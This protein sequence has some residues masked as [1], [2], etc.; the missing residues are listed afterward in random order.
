MKTTKPDTDRRG[1]SALVITTALTLVFLTG[2]GKKNTFVPPPPP[3]VTVAHPVVRD[4]TA[5]HQFTGKTASVA[6]VEIRARVQGWIEKRLFDDGQ[7]VHKGDVL[8]IIDKRPYEAAVQQ[9]K[10]DLLNAKT[11][12]AFA[13]NDLARREKAYKEHAISELDL[14]RSRAERDKAAA[15]VAAAEA[16]LE[17][18]KINLDY[19]TIRSPITGK[20]SRRLVD[21]G[22]LVGA[23]EPTL[24]TTVVQVN[25]IY[26]YFNVSERDVARY[27]KA[28]SEYH[29]AGRR[30]TEQ[31]VIVELGVATEEGYPHRGLL[32]YVDNQVDPET[33]TMQARALIP[34]DDFLL[35]P[36]MFSRIRIP[37]KVLQ[38][39]LLVPQIATAQDQQ[40]RY[41]LVVNGKNVVERR[42]I[43]VGP[44]EGTLVVALKG[45]ERN[46]RVVVNGLLNARPGSEVTPEMTTIEDNGGTPAAS[47]ESGSEKPGTPTKP[48]ENAP[49]TDAAS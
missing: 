1:L 4:V 41:V 10:A 33:G 32:D 2:C 18:A 43:E 26:A 36:G 35:L 22:N 6:S 44:K 13:E 30:G 20:T 15:A 31:K 49:A 12:L 11:G 48:G 34:N 47:P 38:D 19:C 40:G 45:I 14:L 27:L 28:A 29:K 25:P 21:V 9:A 46:D 24:L 17:T 23:G 16:R 8:F 7:V 37:S 39:A 5:Y 3:K 42:G